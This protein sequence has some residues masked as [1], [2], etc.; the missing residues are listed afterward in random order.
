[1]Q[2][3]GITGDALTALGIVGGV[4]GGVGGGANYNIGNDVILSGSS[5]AVPTPQRPNNDDGGFYVSPV[6]GYTGSSSTTFN[7]LGYG[8]S[9]KEVITLPITLDTKDVL[10]PMAINNKLQLPLLVP[11]NMT[12]INNSGLLTSTDVTATQFANMSGI[13]PTNSVAIGNGAGANMLGAMNSVAIGNGA[14]ADVSGL[15]N[16]TYT[17]WQTSSVIANNNITGV[18]MSASGQIQLYGLNLTAQQW[19][20][21]STIYYKGAILYNQSQNNYY[22]VTKDGTINSA[23]AGTNDSNLYSYINPYI[24]NLSLKNGQYVSYQNTVYKITVT[25]VTLGS[26]PPPAVTYNLNDIDSVAPPVTSNDIEMKFYDDTN[27]TSLIT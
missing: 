20:N 17:K 7:V 16:G 12:Y 5:S 21:S 8:S 23:P 19:A 27:Q 22:Y 9:D 4:G 25:G 2:I 14:G 3:V 1:N 10:M 6:L 18:A 11:G 26:I 24:S 13:N 15:S